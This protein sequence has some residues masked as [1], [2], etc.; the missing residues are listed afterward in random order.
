MIGYEI[1][2]DNGSMVCQ[3]VWSRTI[4]IGYDLAIIMGGR[5]NEPLL[6]TCWCELAGIF[7]NIFVLSD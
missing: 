3:C 5:V 7:G 1:A 6:R 2:T 4:V